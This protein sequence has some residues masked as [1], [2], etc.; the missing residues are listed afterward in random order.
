[1]DA[2]KEWHKSRNKGGYG[3]M[4]VPELGKTVLVHRHAIGAKPGD[5]VMHSCDNPACYN[6]NHLKIGTH[7]ENSD[8]ALRK[9]WKLYG[10]LNGQCKL[11]DELYQWIKE[12]PQGPTELG[13]ILGVAHSAISNIRLGKRRTR[14]AAS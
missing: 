6:V 1:M 2:C 13:I 10:E 7:K 8:D 3:V 4:W 9:C 14:N 11:S 12:S 5:V